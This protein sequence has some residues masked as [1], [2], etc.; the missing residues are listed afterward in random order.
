MFRQMYLIPKAKYFELKEMRQKTE[1]QINEVN[2]GGQVT[3]NNGCPDK[4]IMCEENSDEKINTPVIEEPSENILNHILNENKSE[5]ESYPEKTSDE[6][7]LDKVIKKDHNDAQLGLSNQ[8]QKQNTI[9][10]LSIKKLE[11]KIDNLESNLVQNKIKSEPKTPKFSDTIIQQKSSPLQDHSKWEKIDGSFNKNDSENKNTHM[12]SISTTNGIN[13]TSSSDN[14]HII[15]NIE[16]KN[17]DNNKPNE[18]INKE[19]R[20]KIDN[21]LKQSL[22]FDKT[23]SS[24]EKKRL[25]RPMVLRSHTARTEKNE[26]EGLQKKKKKNI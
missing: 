4:V 16:V 5:S 26:L 13:E 23:L 9:D 25:Q 18:K 10:T 1:T 14:S 17:T 3:I 21:R 22:V 12:P 6:Q 19:E 15:G 20:R 8:I 7:T 11:N 2:S 24:K